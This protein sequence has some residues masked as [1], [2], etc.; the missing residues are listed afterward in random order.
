MGCLRL[1][2]SHNGTNG[3]AAFPSQS[4]TIDFDDVSFTTGP[5]PT[6]ES[7]VVL[8]LFGVIVGVRR[9]KS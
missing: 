5:E 2:A 3:P 4:A 8:G 6:T 1:S 9:R 7:L